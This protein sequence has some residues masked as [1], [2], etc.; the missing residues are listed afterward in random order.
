MLQSST[1]LIIDAIGDYRMEYS[2]FCLKFSKLKFEH[3]QFVIKET[4]K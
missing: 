2:R 1:L 4:G 3:S